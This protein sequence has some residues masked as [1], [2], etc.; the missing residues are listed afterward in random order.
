M[1]TEFGVRLDSIVNS[2]REKI[3]E[4]RDKYITQ[5]S[6]PLISLIISLI[7]IIMWFVIIISLFTP[8]PTTGVYWTSVTLAIIIIIVIWL[9]LIA[10]INPNRADGKFNF[11]EILRSAL[12]QARGF[13]GWNL[14]LIICLSFYLIILSR[15]TKNIPT[16]EFW[17]WLFIIISP[18][19]LFLAY[20]MYVFPLGVKKRINFS[21]AYTALAIIILIVCVWSPFALLEVTVGQFAISGSCNEL[22]LNIFNEITASSYDPSG[23]DNTCINLV[24]DSDEIDCDRDKYRYYNK[25]VTYIFLILYFIF[26]LYSVIHSFSFLMQIPEGWPRTIQK[27]V[28][29]KVYQILS[30]IGIYQNHIDCATESNCSEDRMFN[31]FNISEARILRGGGYKKQHSRR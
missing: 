26:I 31:R 4:L 2:I 27:N 19:V 20:F 5:Y 16:K 24:E 25:P 10:L 7:T 22:S 23:V 13:F 15:G 14:P 9:S 29:K 3:V 1:G 30:I 18:F 28:K 17:H 8:V 11:T 12:S 6:L 21:V